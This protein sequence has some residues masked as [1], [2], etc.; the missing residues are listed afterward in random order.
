MILLIYTSKVSSRLYYILNLVF[1]EM[2]E[3]EYEITNEV[4]TFQNYQGPK[5]NYSSKV[6]NDEP[7]I[8]AHQILFESGIHQ[9][10][11]DTTEY[12]GIPVLF[13]S[14]QPASLPYDPLAAAFFMVSRYEEY[15]PFRGDSYGRFRGERSIAY[16]K[17]FH[18]IPVVNHYVE[19]IKQLLHHYY[20]SMRFGARS[21]QFILTYDID[22]AY[23]FLE[24]GAMRSQGA[25]LKALITGDKDFIETRKKVLTGK[26]PDPYDTFDYQFY[27]NNKYQVYPIYFFHLGDYGTNDKS[28]PWTSER[29]QNLIRDINNRYLTGLH[30]SFASNSKFKLLGLEIDRLNAITG[31]PT[32]RSRQHYIML[33][34]PDTYNILTS[35]GINDDYSMGYHNILG[36][37]AGICTPFHFYDINREEQTSLRIHPFCAMDSTLHHQLNL[38]SETALEEVKQYVDEVRKVNGTFTFIAHNNLIGAQSEF[39]GWSTQFEELIKYAK[40]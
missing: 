39:A 28:I 36:F 20:P 4:Q 2:M 31:K 32:I 12:Q 9:Q 22:I 35:I 19:H 17:S 29:L 23:S 24:K 18:F 37:R 3:I 16:K 14:N 1:R 26:M 8:S 40:E 27:L 6:F 25:L 21:Y 38:T 33:K 11:T 5:L 10:R 15:L 13:A 7:F 34:F 30:P